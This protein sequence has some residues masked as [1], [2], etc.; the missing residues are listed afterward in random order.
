MHSRRRSASTKCCLIGFCRAGSDYL[1]L[2]AAPS[3]LDRCY[4]LEAAPCDTVLEVVRENVPWIAVD[5]PHLWT[6]WAKQVVLGADH[7]V[8]TAAPDLA[9][10]RN[11][12]NLVDHLKAARPNDRPPV[13]VLNQVGMPK[14]P[15]ISVKDFGDAIGLEPKIVIDFDAQLFGTAANNGQMVEELSEKSKAAEALRSLANYLTDRSEQKNERKSL[16]GPILAR[17]GLTK[18]RL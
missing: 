16:L 17:L 10:L 12:K 1:S 9:S 2:F 6:A 11:T 7:V 3:T 13:L 15:E 8:I 5:V 14:R 18:K 4:A